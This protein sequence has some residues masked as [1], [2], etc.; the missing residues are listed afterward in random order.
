MRRAWRPGGVLECTEFARRPDSAL[1]YRCQLV[2]D[3]CSDLLDRHRSRPNLGPAHAG[4]PRRAGRAGDGGHRHRRRWAATGWRGTCVAARRC[5]RCWRSAGRGAWSAGAGRASRRSCPRPRASRA[6]CA[7]A[8]ART[9]ASGTARSARCRCGR[10]LLLLSLQVATGL[11]ADDDIATTG[12]LN[13]HVGGHL[14][15]RASGWH[16]GWGADLILALI[17][18]H[19]LA[20]GWYT[21]RRREPLLRAMW[22]GDKPLPPATPAEP[23][24]RGARGC[25]RWRSGRPPRPA[26]GRSCAGPADAAATQPGDRFGVPARRAP[27]PGAGCRGAW[28]T[29]V[30]LAH[31]FGLESTGLVQLKRVFPRETGAD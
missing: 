27:R 15:R 12:P 6:R 16:A 4:V 2:H 30:A 29:G 23:R 26:S 18:L 21:L 11:V 22:T 17:A 13:A 10:F 31:P 5:W 25:S 8:R 1:A 20:I 24:R 9:T 3:C 19:V 7:D 14:A 28:C